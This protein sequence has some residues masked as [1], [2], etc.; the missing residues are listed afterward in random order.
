M[1]GRH[2]ATT[3]SSSSADDATFPYYDVKAFG[4][5]IAA[6]RKPRTALLARFRTALAAVD[7]FDAAAARSRPAA[8]RG[9]AEE[10][11][12]RTAIIHAVRVAVT[13]KAVGF[14]LFEAMA[15]LG[16]DGLCR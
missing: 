16:R 14:G 13:G 1:A 6:R 8:F 3:P 9:D 11:P 2:R 5:R 12:D 15:I 4:K 10:H 7:P